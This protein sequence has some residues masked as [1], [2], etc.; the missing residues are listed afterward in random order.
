MEA[1]TEW[2]TVPYPNREECWLYSSQYKKGEPLMGRYFE[3]DNLYEW[4]VFEN[5]SSGTLKESIT[6]TASSREQAAIQVYHHCTAV[7]SGRVLRF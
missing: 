4:Q 5:L 6:G 7:S 1:L 3:R 2:R